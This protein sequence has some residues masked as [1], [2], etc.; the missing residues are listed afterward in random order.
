MRAAPS[1]WTSSSS[2]RAA[3]RRAAASTSP[4]AP[5]RCAERLLALAVL[6]RVH[7]IVRQAEVMADLVD[8]HVTD[9]VAQGLFVLRPI[10]EDR[11]AIEEDRRLAA[12]RLARL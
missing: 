7:L 4:N 8:Q 10:V 11:A 12:M 9:D 1:R 5:I 2:S 6:D 3:P